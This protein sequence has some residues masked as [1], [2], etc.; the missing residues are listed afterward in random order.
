[1]HPHD[2]LIVL[3]VMEIWRLCLGFNVHY[4]NEFERN[5]K[6][7]TTE[8]AFVEH[9]ESWFNCYAYEFHSILSYFG[10][11]IMQVWF[12]QTR[13]HHIFMVLIYYPSIQS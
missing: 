13:S 1:M 10:H 12:V 4:E 5:F 2:H 6:M 8:N 7:V 9:V 11:I 3:V